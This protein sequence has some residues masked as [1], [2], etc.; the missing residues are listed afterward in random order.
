MG[1]IALSLILSFWAFS[2][3]VRSVL[4]SHCHHNRVCCYSYPQRKII[5]FSTCSSLLIPFLFEVFVVTSF[6]L[7]CFIL[8]I[9]L[10][11]LK[12]CL[13]YFWF[14]LI[15]KVII[16]TIVVNLTGLP[17]I[18][19]TLLSIWL[20]SMPCFGVFLSSTVRS[21]TL[22]NTSKCSINVPLYMS[23]PV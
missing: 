12:F 17:S 21:S 15:H 11:C 20:D 8:F 19:L 16:A 22:S 23:L 14:Y 2:A 18:V 1:A 9:L 5:L 4:F 10:V 7:F 13:F 3:S 6:C